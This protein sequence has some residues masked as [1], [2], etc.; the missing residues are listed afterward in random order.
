MNEMKENKTK[1]TQTYSK[2]MYNTIDEE[3]SLIIFLKN[4]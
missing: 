1:E 2:Y 3:S 4:I